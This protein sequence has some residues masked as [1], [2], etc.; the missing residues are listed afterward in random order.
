VHEVATVV[1]RIAPR[2][3]LGRPPTANEA[4]KYEEEE[5]HVAAMTT[6]NLVSTIPLFTSW[7]RAQSDVA[8]A[9][10]LLAACCDWP[11]PHPKVH[12]FVLGQARLQFLNDRRTC[13]DLEVQL[14]VF[15][16][17]LVP[18]TV[19]S[20]WVGAFRCSFSPPL[21]I[22]EYRSCADSALRAA[23]LLRCECG[24]VG[25]RHGDTPGAKV[26]EQ[27]LPE[28]QPV[29]LNIAAPQRDVSIKC[30]YTQLV[31]E[32]EVAHLF[33]N[34]QL[35]RAEALHEPAAADARRRLLDAAG[36]MHLVE[37]GPSTSG[38]GVL[39]AMVAACV[40]AGLVDLFKMLSSAAG[41]ALFRAYVAGHTVPPVHNGVGRGL[42][43]TETHAVAMQQA[44]NSLK[45]A[46]AEGCAATAEQLPPLQP[47]PGAWQLIG[48]QEEQA[49]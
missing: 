16:S 3:E 17:P 2:P 15:P 46:L 20:E 34:L 28:K 45:L 8:A 43:L 18:A 30:P 31:Q 39:A 12:R 42:L 29:P 47:P 24:G 37:P 26:W 27:L 35:G 38:Q 13:L 7:L 4:Q 5:E 19:V 44:L 48:A 22:W 32:G 49:R 25:V 21:Q 1:R 23:R 40:A 33:P 36:V 9:A 6:L 41:R 11:F 14:A 10:T